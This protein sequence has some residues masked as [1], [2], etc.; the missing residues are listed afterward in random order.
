ML[1][2]KLQYFGHLMWRISSLEIH[3][4][5]ERLK[6]GGEGDDRGWDGWTASTTQWTWVWANP[7]D[8]ERQGSLAC[9]SPWGH[10]ESDM[11]EQLNWRKG[12]SAQRNRRGIQGPSYG[13]PFKILL[14][15]LLLYPRNNRR[16]CKVT[17]LDMYFLKAPSDCG[18]NHWQ[19]EGKK[20]ADTAIKERK[21]NELYIDHYNISISETFKVYSTINKEIIWWRT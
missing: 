16:T 11:T 15:C 1:R 18:V 12:E 3:W 8:S 14:K 21:D 7:G 9:C 4:C 20:E 5:W 6:A 2:L 10:K 13:R 17:L 19:E